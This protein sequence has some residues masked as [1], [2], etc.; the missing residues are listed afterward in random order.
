MGTCGV[1]TEMKV[2]LSEKISDIEELASSGSSVLVS[3]EYGADSVFVPAGVSGVMPTRIL[4]KIPLSTPMAG[5]VVFAAPLRKQ[6][7][8]WL[9]RAS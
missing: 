6:L 9:L 7:Y 4:C 1:T 5:T 8:P 2:E 3:D